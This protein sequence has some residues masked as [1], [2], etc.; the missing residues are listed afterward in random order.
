MY[1]VTQ[2]VPALGIEVGDILCDD[3]VGMS[4]SRELSG[5]ETILAF[6]PLFARPV[7]EQAEPTLQLVRGG[8]R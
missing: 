1:L 5:R 2:A 4:V 7:T 3:G 8:A 6:L